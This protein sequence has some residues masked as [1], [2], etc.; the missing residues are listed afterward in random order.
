MSE[1]IEL[2]TMSSRGQLVIP[3]DIRENMGLKEGSKVLF[4][5]SEDSLLIKRVNTQ[6]FAEITKP[7]KEA[8]KKAGLKE[9]DTE[10]IIQKVRS[11]R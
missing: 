11:K 8:A 9:S 10:D 7:L 5:L 3:T 6:T 2:G 1:L 4:V